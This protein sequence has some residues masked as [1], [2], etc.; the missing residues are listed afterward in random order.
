VKV[1]DFQ[2]GERYMFNAIV[3]GS[4]PRDRLS[5]GQ[6]VHAARQTGQPLETGKQTKGKRTALAVPTRS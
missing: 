2:D 1:E 5:G 4:K 6:C 3:C